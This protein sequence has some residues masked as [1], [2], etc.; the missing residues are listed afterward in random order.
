MAMVFWCSVDKCVLMSIECLSMLFEFLFAFES[1]M[2][3]KLF[4]IT[5]G[6]SV[7]LAAAVLLHAAMTHMMAVRWHSIAV[8]VYALVALLGAL[9]FCVDLYVY[10][11]FWNDDSVVIAILNF[12]GIIML[13]VLYLSPL[14]VGCLILYFWSRYGAAA[15]NSVSNSTSISAPI[16]ASKEP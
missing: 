14:L 4:V 10:R 7:L 11:K 6:I 1:N 2:L 5:G 9:Q 8:R 13:D 12:I 3:I 15:Q 16:S